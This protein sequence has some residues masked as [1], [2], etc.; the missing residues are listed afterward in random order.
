[1]APVKGKNND[2]LEIKET[3]IYIRFYQLT[4]IFQFS[5]RVAYNYDDLQKSLI[6][7]KNDIASCI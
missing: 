6:V 1:M 3:C 7:N 4:N 2:N 5:L